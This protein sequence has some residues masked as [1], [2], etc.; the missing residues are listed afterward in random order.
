MQTVSPGESNGKRRLRRNVDKS[1]LRYLIQSLIKIYICKKKSKNPVSPLI[2]N[3]T[4]QLLGI[5]YRL[6]V[7]LHQLQME[8]GETVL[9]HQ[10]H[11]QTTSLFTSEEILRC[12]AK[13]TG[14]DMSQV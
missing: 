11:N 2:T 5:I 1:V 4:D 8:A 10:N 9:S 14:S 3:Q 13:H 7:K 6:L 12:T